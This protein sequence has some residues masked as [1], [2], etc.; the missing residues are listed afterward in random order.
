MGDHRVAC[1]RRAGRPRSSP[2]RISWVSRLAAVRASSRV[3]ASVTP[4]PSRSEGSAT[5]LL[6]EGLD[7]GGGAVDQ[8]GADVERPE[9]GD[10]HQDVAEV[11]VG[12]DRAVHGHHERL[13][14]E[15]RDVPEDAPEVGRSHARNVSRVGEAATSGS[16]AGRSDILRAPP[17]HDPET[18]CPTSGSS[19]PA[20]S[21]RTPSIACASGAGSRSPRPGPAAAEG[22]RPREGPLGDP[23]L[24]TT[25]R[26][27]STKRSSRPARP[28]GSSVVSQIAV[29]VDNIDR[30][31]AN[32]HRI[33]YTHTPDVLT[34]ATAEYAFFMMGAVAR[35]LYPA[36]VQVR[37]RE[38]TTWH[39]YLPW[40]GDEVTG[41]TLA[42]VGMGRIGQSMAQGGRLRHGRALPQRRR[43]APSRLRRPRAAGDGP[44][45][46]RGARR[47]G[48]QTIEV[49]LPRGRAAA[50]R[51]R[52]PPR[53]PDDAGTAAEPTFH[54]IDEARL[55]LMKP[56]AY[57]V[58][59]ARGPV[60]DEQALA[61]ALREGWIAGAALDV[62]ETEPL[63][64]DSPLRDEALAPEAAPLPARG[65]G[66]AR[67]P[68]FRPTPTSAW[69]AAACRARS[70]CSRAATAATRSRCRSSSTKRPSDS[71][72]CPASGEPTDDRPRRLP[73]P[74]HVASSAAAGWASS[75]RP[76]TRSS[77]GTSR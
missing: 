12:D 34:D 64:D 39:P 55:R 59:T 16:S 73:L 9:H 19:P 37:A 54:L 43:S 51:L 68:A 7:L 8:H 46:P 42:V 41:R 1:W 29:G 10:V 40:L 15:L 77:A 22:A 5:A 47:R 35:K 44:A 49:V 70:T 71:I 45:A 74:G 76:R 53:A 57:L 62:F 60:V 61:R 3:A 26:D 32:R 28:R 67:H 18:R 48:A 58:N 20:T 38:W 52:L 6:G 75:T 2:S 31:A 21:G 65:L 17:A 50:G 66:G 24:V 14:A 69:P 30:A 72:A 23:G 25:L 56:T 63:P 36:E 33:P 11:L 4:E 27:P 13:L